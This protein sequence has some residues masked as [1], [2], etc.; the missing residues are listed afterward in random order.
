METDDATKDSKETA[1][2]FTVSKISHNWREQ[3]FSLQIKIKENV[4]RNL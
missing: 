1:T 4:A 2:A 3:S